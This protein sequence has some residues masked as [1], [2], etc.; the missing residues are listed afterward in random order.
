MPPLRCGTPGRGP[1]WP[2]PLPRPRARAAGQQ[3]SGCTSSCLSVVPPVAPDVA[4][5]DALRRLIFAAVGIARRHHAARA[6]RPGLAV[7]EL[8]RRTPGIVRRRRIIARLAAF[9]E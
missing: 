3:A 9:E 6:L 2:T 4:R 8:H 5:I 1:G 7:I